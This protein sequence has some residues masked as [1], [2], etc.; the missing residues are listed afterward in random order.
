MIHSHLREYEVRTRRTQNVF[1]SAVQHAA[2][3]TTPKITG[4]RRQ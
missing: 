3:E 4:K 2:T 1:R